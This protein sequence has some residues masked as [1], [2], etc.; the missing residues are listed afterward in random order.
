M[1]PQAVCVDI[2]GDALSL[3]WLRGNPRRDIFYLVASHYHWATEIA[4][5]L[6]LVFVP[7]SSGD[8]FLSLKTQNAY[9]TRLL[10]TTTSFIEQSQEHW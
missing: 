1:P 5:E 8:K 9:L 10:A 3:A 7:V 6:T 4:A 2:A